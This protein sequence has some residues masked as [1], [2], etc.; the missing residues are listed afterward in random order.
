MWN[1]HRGIYVYVFMHLHTSV[2]I[3]YVYMVH[4]LQL[5]CFI[6]I[7]QYLQHVTQKFV[8]FGQKSNFK[9]FIYAWLYTWGYCY[10]IVDINYVNYICAI[11]VSLT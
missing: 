6:C 1:T 10:L 3:Q 2:Y 8:Q 11:S 9:D 7:V 5:N 4:Q